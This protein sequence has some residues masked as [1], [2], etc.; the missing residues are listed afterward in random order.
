[1]IGLNR[2]LVGDARASCARCRTASSTA[3]SRARRTSGCATTSTPGS[4]DWKST[5]SSGSNEL[6]GVLREAWPRAG[7]DRLGLAQPRRQ[8]LDRP[9]GRAG[10]EPAARP[11]AAGPGA[12]RGRLDRSAT[13]SS[14]RSA[15]R[16]QARRR[17]RLS[18]TWEVVYLLVR[19]RD[20]FFDLDAIRVPH[21]T[22]KTEPEDLASVVGAAR[23]AGVDKQ[24]QRPGRAQ[25]RRPSRAPA[26][27]E[28][29]RCLAAARPPPTAAPTT[30]SS[31]SALAE[32]PIRAGCPERRCTPLPAPLEAADDPP[33]RAP[34]RPRRAT[35]ELRL[36]RRLGA[37]GRARS[38]H[39]LRHTAIAAEQHGR[40][41]LGIELNPTFA[42]ARHARGSRRRAVNEQRRA[43]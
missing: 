2:I 34:R 6:R 31:R 9:R 39:R 28:P 41:W 7:P 3:S 26:R 43:A 15:T 8:L 21:T 19:Q 4:S 5:S 27:Q 17:D 25:R 22:T 32:R 37:G 10:Q 29:R 35:A 14:G 16:C 1:M 38:V 13:R 18:C 33:A 42:A 36:P 24:Q 20:Y 30:P 23:L 12:D 11:G 40:D